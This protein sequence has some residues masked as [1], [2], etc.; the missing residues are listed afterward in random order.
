MNIW[1]TTGRNDQDPLSD[2]DLGWVGPPLEDDVEDGLEA[3]LRPRLRSTAYRDEERDEG[4]LPDVE[5][6][7]E[8]EVERHG[9]VAPER[10]AS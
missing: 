7:W 5:E 9:Y 10:W 8:A 4:S 6:L 1:Y 3:P 2:L